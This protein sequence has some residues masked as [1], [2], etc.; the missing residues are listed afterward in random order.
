MGED[1]QFILVNEAE[2]LRQIT[3]A[4]ESVKEVLL[5]AVLAGAEIVQDGAEDRAPGPHIEMDVS[6]KKKLKVSVDVGPDDDHWYYRFFE[7]GAQPHEISPKNQE[8]LLL[9]GETFAARAA[10][11]GMPAKPFLRP[12]ADK[13]KDEVVEAIGEVILERL[14]QIAVSG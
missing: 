13:S 14:K 8:A 7:F 9:V 3:A 10:H 12:A 11:P 6:E 1:I 4:G 5:E 2:V